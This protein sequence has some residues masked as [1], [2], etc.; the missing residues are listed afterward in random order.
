MIIF[1]LNIT[2]IALMQM[3]S[4]MLPFYEVDFTDSVY[5]IILNDEVML[6]TMFE[7]SCKPECDTNMYETF[8]EFP[9]HCFIGEVDP[10]QFPDMDFLGYRLPG[11]YNVAICRAY[12]LY[13]TIVNTGNYW[14]EGSI[15][16]TI[17]IISAHMRS[18]IYQ[19]EE[20]RAI[21]DQIYQPPIHH[22]NYASIDLVNNIE[23][24]N[25]L[26]IRQINADTKIFTCNQNF[27]FFIRK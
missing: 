9:K 2:M 27:T 20:Q 7:V 13:D 15:N 8:E 5:N 18:N 24:N 14:N 19:L 25:V 1:K 26:N 22:I 3:L 10:E 6:R 17:N 4:S 12:R 23:M 21:H 11:F 16:S